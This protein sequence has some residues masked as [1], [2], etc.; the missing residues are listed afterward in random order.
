MH[1]H[2]VLAYASMVV[3]MVPIPSAHGDHPQTWVG[4]ITFRLPMV[5]L[6]PCPAIALNSLQIKVGGPAGATADCDARMHAY[7]YART[8]GLGRT[9]CSRWRDEGAACMHIP[10]MHASISTA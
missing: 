5:I 9:S 1:V 6:E 10:N 3:H 4:Y 7:E 2:V 8:R